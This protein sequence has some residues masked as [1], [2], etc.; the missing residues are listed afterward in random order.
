MSDDLRVV[1]LAENSR[2]GNENVGARGFHVGDVVGLDAAVDLDVEREAA[3]LKLAANLAQL[4]E[5]L[6]NEMLAAESR[7]HTHDENH[8]ELLG[9]RNHSI[10]RGFGIDSDRRARTEVMN[11][12]RDLWNVGAN[13]A[14]HRD[15][16][17][18]RFDKNPDVLFRL[19]DHQMRI[20]RELGDFANRFQ[21]RHTHRDVGHEMAVHHVEMKQ[22]RSGTLDGANFLAESR[23][24]GSE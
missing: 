5:R 13:F 19:A 18:A 22:V 17:G 8:V 14:M 10:D 16:I 20:E 12:F 2:T 15:R 11:L 21:N 23:E 4:L 7:M 24:V 3:P 1:L 6:R 9:G